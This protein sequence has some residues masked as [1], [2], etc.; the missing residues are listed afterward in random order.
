MMLGMS[1]TFSLFEW[2]KDNCQEHLVLQEQVAEA[3]KNTASDAA[4]S[5]SNMTI[6]D[7]AEVK[8]LL[9]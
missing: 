9:N 4:T 5:I 3:I 7:N 6:N 8:L 2:V 1:M